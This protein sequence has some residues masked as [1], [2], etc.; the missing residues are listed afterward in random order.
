MTR[1]ET[2]FSVQF[3]HY[4]ILIILITYQLL[5]PVPWYNSA[6]VK[7]GVRGWEAATDSDINWTNSL[8]LKLRYSLVVVW[9]LGGIF[10]FEQSRLIKLHGTAINQRGLLSTLNLA[11]SSAKGKELLKYWISRWV[12]APADPASL[13]Q[14]LSFNGRMVSFKPLSLLC[15]IPITPFEHG[16][17]L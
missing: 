3:Y 10:P 2:Y 8:I 17:M 16:T 5:T 15:F 4:L 13:S 7:V 12:A 1:F 6:P 9:D 11:Q 14:A